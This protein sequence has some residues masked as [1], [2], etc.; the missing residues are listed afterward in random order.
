MNLYLTR[1][2]ELDGGTY[3]RLEVVGHDLRVWTLERSWQS[4]EPFVSCVPM[5]TYNLQ[6]HDSTKF[7][8]TVALQGGSVSHFPD[9]KAV[10]SS[11]LFHAA[12]WPNELQGCIAVGHG[13][14]MSGPTLY[15][16]KD[17]LAAL[18][19]CLDQEDANTLTIG[20]ERG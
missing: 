11:I 8:R 19:A 3:G 17:A 1:M 13:L 4:N 9:G 20:G 15:D 18:M 7:G 10:R 12:N 2:F 16:S 14:K 6:W 5:G